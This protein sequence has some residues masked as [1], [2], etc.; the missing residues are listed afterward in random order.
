MNRSAVIERVTASWDSELPT[1]QKASFAA[2][3]NALRAD[4][5][6]AVSLAGSF[7]GVLK[8]MQAA[9]RSAGTTGERAKAV[10]ETT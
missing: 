3:L 4:E 6:L 7:D 5:L 1:A 2:H 10:G 8:I 9:Q